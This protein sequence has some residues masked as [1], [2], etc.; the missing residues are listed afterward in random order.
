VRFVAEN[1]EIGIGISATLVVLRWRLR[2]VV[3]FVEFD[4]CRSRVLLSDLPD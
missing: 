1:Y 4:Q 2:A 3:S